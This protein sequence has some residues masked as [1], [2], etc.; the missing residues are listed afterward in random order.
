MTKESMAFGHNQG[1]E[2]LVAKFSLLMTMHG[3]NFEKVEGRHR[4]REGS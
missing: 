4:G 2:D 3:L 1:N